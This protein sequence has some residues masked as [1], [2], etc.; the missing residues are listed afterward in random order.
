M[1]R[2]GSA[3]DTEVLGGPG[4]CESGPVKLRLRH[5]LLVEVSLA[6]NE[7]MACG[8]VVRRGIT[9]NL[10]APQFVEVAIAVDA[11]VVRDVDPPVLVLVIPLVFAY[12]VRGISVRAEDHCL[13]VQGHP[14]DGVTLAARAGRSR[15]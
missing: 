6:E 13:V 10:G 15:A 8:V 5:G 11:D 3:R 7:E 2:Q 12:A 1:T 4:E 14:R 9:G